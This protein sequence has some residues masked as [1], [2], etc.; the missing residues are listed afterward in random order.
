MNVT[1]DFAATEASATPSCSGAAVA[2][3]QEVGYISGDE[4][5]FAV[6]FGGKRGG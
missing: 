3:G 2:Q 1:K 5:R 6:L 4:R